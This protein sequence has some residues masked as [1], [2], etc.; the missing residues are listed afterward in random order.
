MRGA[1]ATKVS[2]SIAK[3]RG[4]LGPMQ[5]RGVEVELAE[6]AQLEQLDAQVKAHLP[7]EAAES[8]DEEYY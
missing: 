6:R 2:S 3:V 5:Q 4:L 1:A 7:Q 8:D